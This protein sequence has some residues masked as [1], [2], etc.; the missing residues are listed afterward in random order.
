MKPSRRLET[1]NVSQ[2]QYTYCGRTLGLASWRLS[3]LVVVLLLAGCAPGAN[4]VDEQSARGPLGLSE[5]LS[6]SGD[7]WVRPDLDWPVLETGHQFVHA[8]RPR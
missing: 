8:S 6:A 1:T 7:A 3:P 4:M 5:R 2:R